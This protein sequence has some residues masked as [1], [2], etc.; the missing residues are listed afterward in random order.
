[1]EA[2][3]YILLKDSWGLSKSTLK[4]LIPAVPYS[5]VIILR[6]ELITVKQNSSSETKYQLHRDPNVYVK[7]INEDIAPLNKQDFLLMEGI[8]KPADRMEAFI[9]E[10]LDWG[11]TLKEGSTVYV[12]LNTQYARAV[13]HYK[14][15]IGNVPGIRFGMEFL[16]S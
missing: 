6:G 7:C 5:E 11:I 9:N 4:K 16:V 15:V 8:E 2:A 14:G 13:V 3:G 12:I 1:M 10:K